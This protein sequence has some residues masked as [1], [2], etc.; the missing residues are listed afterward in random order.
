MQ[1]ETPDQTAEYE[2]PAIRSLG[3]VDEL[4]HGVPDN[5]LTTTTLDG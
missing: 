4:T 3:S 1:A 5:S 2:S